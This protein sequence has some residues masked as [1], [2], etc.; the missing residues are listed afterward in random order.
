MWHHPE[1]TVVLSGMSD[2][3][4]LAEN[5]RIADEIDSAEVALASSELELFDRVRSILNQKIKVG[6]TACGY[7]LPCPAG[8]AVPEMMDAYNH[9]LLQPHK[10]AE[11]AITDRLHWHWEKTPAAAE[12]CTACGLCEKRCTQHLPIK[13]R[14]K[15]IAAIKPT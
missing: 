11:K 14:M 7:C 12:P 9:S 15:Q 6:C 1:A 4:Q 8:I 10:P 3:A 13:E 5:L 2:E